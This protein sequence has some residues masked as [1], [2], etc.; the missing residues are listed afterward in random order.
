M[1]RTSNIEKIISRQLLGEKLTSEEQKQLQTW[2]DESERNHRL[3]DELRGEYF[4]VNSYKAYRRIDSDKAWK[5]FQKATLRIQP[6]LFHRFIKYAA[7]LILPL[8][9]AGT[10]LYSEYQ[11]SQRNL[12]AVIVPGSTGAVFRTAE[13]KTMDLNEE[14]LKEGLLEKEEQNILPTSKGI[15]MKAKS[16]DE[17]TNASQTKEEPYELQTLGNGEFQITLEDGTHVHLN[18]NTTLRFPVHFSNKERVVYLKGEAFFKVAKDE[19]R[20][21]KVLT[22]NVAI[23][24][25]GTTFNVNTYSSSSTKVVLVEGSIGVLSN[26]KEYP[27]RP[28]EC[29]TFHNKTSKVDIKQVDVTPY[30]AWHDGRFIFDNETLSEIMSTLSHWYGVKVVFDDPELKKLHFTGN[31]SRYGKIHPLLNSISLTVGIKITLNDRV[32]HV[33]NEE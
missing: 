4:D 7:I 14:T 29:L 23:K 30:V 1:L 20:P 22:D 21:F 28:S 2:L 25:Y 26:E 32:I 3:Y 9:I 27:I 16:S 13:G 18:Y 15:I 10:I 12:T 8:V 11:S 19:T 31:M 33:A 24:Q 6:T 5:K 17:E